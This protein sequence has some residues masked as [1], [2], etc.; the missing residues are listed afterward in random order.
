MKV[1]KGRNFNRNPDKIKI[2]AAWARQYLDGQHK[3]S[4][5]IFGDTVQVVDASNANLV[6]GD[7]DAVV[8]CAHKRLTPPEDIPIDH[9]F[10]EGQFKTGQIVV[11]F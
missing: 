4:C 2:P 6:I 1:F 10:D 7:D 9:L 11:S 3:F 8:L 5:M